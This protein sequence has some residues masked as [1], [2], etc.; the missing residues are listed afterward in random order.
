MSPPWL[1]H[2]DLNPCHDLGH[3]LFKTCLIH[4]SAPHTSHPTN[5][6]SFIVV[7]S[8]F[9]PCHHHQTTLSFFTIVTRI[10]VTVPNRRQLDGDPPHPTTELNSTSFQRATRK[11]LYCF[12]LVSPSAA[13]IDLTTP[14]FQSGSS[15]NFT[16]SSRR[17]PLWPA[18]R[19]GLSVDVTVTS[20]LGFVPCH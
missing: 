11:Q 5:A 4:N 12:N 1:K 8:P 15:E 17:H 10:F 7:V 2:P 19:W 14:V 3:Y 9:P 13:P 18:L 6:R 16:L 20:E